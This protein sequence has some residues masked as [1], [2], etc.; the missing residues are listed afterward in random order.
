MCMSSIPTNVSW[1][2]SN[3]LNPNIGRVTRFTPRW[4]CSIILFNYLILRMAIAVPCPSLSLLVAASL[5]ALPRHQTAPS[6]GECR[7]DRLAQ[8]DGCGG[9]DRPRGLG[10]GLAI[11]GSW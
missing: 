9:W 2:A 6:G 8:V 5:A 4:S 7:N 1:A 3:D 11:G 10:G